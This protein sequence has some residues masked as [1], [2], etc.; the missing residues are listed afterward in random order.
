MYVKRN[1]KGF[2]LILTLLALSLLSVIGFGMVALSTVH[3]KSM[4]ERMTR[5]KA[6][7]YARAGIGQALATLKTNYQWTGGES[8]IVQNNDGDMQEGYNVVVVPDANNPNTP[9]KTWQITSTGYCDGS[10]RKLEAWLDMETFAL[11]ALFF[12]DGEGTGFTN[13]DKMDGKVHTN[14]RFKLYGSPRFADRATSSNV[15]RDSSGSVTWK[16]PDYD[17]TN[18]R[19]KMSGSNYTDDPS[20]FYWRT[21]TSGSDYGYD[22]YYIRDMDGNPTPENLAGAQPDIPLPTYNNPDMYG[23]STPKYFDYVEAHCNGYV[24]ERDVY[25]YFS[26]DGTITMKN[27][28]G[29]MINTNKFGDAIVNPVNAQDA[30]IKVIGNVYIGYPRDG[31]AEKMKGRT[32]IIAASKNSSTGYIKVQDSVVYKDKETDILGLVAEK[33]VQIMTGPYDVG[34][35]EIDASIMT[36]NGSVT[37]NQCTSGRRRGDLIIYGGVVCKALAG[38]ENASCTTGYGTKWSYDP[39]LYMKP[40]VNWPLTGKIRAVSIKDKGSLN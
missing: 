40:P 38:T 39:K 23:A 2:A 33:D 8:I 32:T 19:Y 30:T 22:R 11:W 1:R 24:F 31:V 26:E 21:S 9:Y 18:N 3:S 7:S 17:L 27:S 25:F 15:Q 34:D 35:L 37:V 20:R 14:R 5:V 28:S 36:L 13:E 12:D 16:D 10:K 4:K 6:Y 29:N